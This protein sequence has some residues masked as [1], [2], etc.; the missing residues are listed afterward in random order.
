MSDTTTVNALPPRDS[1]QPEPPPAPG[2]RGNAFRHALRLTCPG[3]GDTPL[4]RSLF[5]MHH[6][7]PRCGLSFQRETGFYLGSIY[8][9][10]GATV[11]GTG[12]LYAL[13]VLVLGWS[14]QAA[15]TA[16]L[17][18]AVVFPVLFFRH[19]RAFLLAL[20]GAVNRHQSRLPR[21]PTTADGDTLGAGDLAN[22]KAD[23]ANAGC[24]MGIALVLIL[25]FGLLMAA[26]ALV[27]VGGFRV[28]PSH[29]ADAVDLSRLTR[30]RTT[31]AL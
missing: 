1:T 13:L 4:F 21:A 11:I 20:D 17:V 3:C 16:A 25:L 7:C 28:T 27:A 9:N 15:L 19:A 22:L 31:M 26:A 23:D 5:R 29:D 14:Q 10:Y 30:P 6:A 24:M 8:I 2:R 12:L 18:V